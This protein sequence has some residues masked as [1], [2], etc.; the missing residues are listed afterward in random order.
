[1]ANH[2]RTQVS[3]DGTLRVWKWSLDLGEGYF[4]PKCEMTVSKISLSDERKEYLKSIEEAS[5]LNDKRL[6]GE[7]EKLKFQVD[8]TF[9]V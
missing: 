8:L 4:G 3:S 2:I 9:Q 7:A 5:T 6:R 1:M